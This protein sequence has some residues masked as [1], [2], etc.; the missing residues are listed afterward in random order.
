MSAVSRVCPP[1]L[2]D[3]L[4]V[5]I[6]FKYYLTELSST[7]LIYYTEYYYYDDCCVA[8]TAL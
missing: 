2:H 6:Q 5:S 8:G 4:R 7:I 1:R 3:K